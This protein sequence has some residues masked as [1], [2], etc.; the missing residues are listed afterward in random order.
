MFDSIV[1]KHLQR[2]KVVIT[3]TKTTQYLHG[4]YESKSG[5]IVAAQ[6][7]PDQHEQTARVRFFDTDEERSFAIKYIAP[8]EPKYTDED[9]LVLRGK[10]QGMVLVVREKP[11]MDLITVSSRQNPVA[12]DY[13]Q[14]KDVVALT[15]EA[16]R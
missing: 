7:A 15:E 1:A 5:R 4:D 3:G 9:V 8:Q 12:F 6:R 10:Q 16:S 11:D 2:I 13:V 14:K